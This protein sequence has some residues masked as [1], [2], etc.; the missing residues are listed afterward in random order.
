MTEE[1]PL[2]EATDHVTS[3]NP[4]LGYSMRK[5]AG[6]QAAEQTY[7]D[8]ATVL[9]CASIQGFNES[10][11]VHT[12]INYWGYRF[13][14]GERLLAPN[15]STAPFQLIDVKDVASFAIRVLE[16]DLSGAYNMVGPVGI[17]LF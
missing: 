7:G 2:L 1:G 6:E 9:R 14:C 4:E 11:E 5:R 12:R 10:P 15:D 8:R 16:E 13:L 17:R 3:M